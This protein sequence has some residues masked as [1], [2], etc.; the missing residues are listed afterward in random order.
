[1][2]IRLNDVRRGT[3]EY[4]SLDDRML[5]LDFQ[6][7]NPEAFVEIHKRYGGLA[8]HVCR[9]LLAN[10]HDAE[11]ALQETMIR[12]F[13][14]LYRFNG[15]YKLQPWISRIA[16]NVSLDMIRARARRPV[17]DDNAVDEHDHVDP[18]DRPEE[19]FER[20]VQRD[21]VLS[22][23][24]DLPDTHRHALILRELEGRSHR[25]IGAAMGISSSQAKALIH[26]AKGSFRR[27]W[28][29]KVAERGGLAGVAFLPLLWLVRV[30]DTV[31]RV[32]DRAGQT[33]QAAQTAVPEVVT[34]AATQSVVATTSSS[35]FGE[36]VIAAGMT[37]L[38]AG[39]VTVGATA[40]A[41]HDRD[42]DRQGARA[43]ASPAVVQPS[44]QP[45][46]VIEPK[47]ERE[48]VIE[49]STPKEALVPPLVIEAEEVVEPSPTVSP[50]VT[51]ETPSPVPTE[52]PSPEPT[53][54]PSPDPVPT[55]PPPPAWSFDTVG[56]GAGQFE[57]TSSKVTGRAG[58]QVVFSE[59][60]VAPRSDSGGSRTEWVHVEYWGSMIDSSG[61]TGLWL[62]VD[63]PD[64]TY[65]FDGRGF[66]T[67][68]SGAKGEGVTYEF[69]GSYA[70]A[71]QQDSS[72]DPATTDTLPLHGG[73]FVLRLR[74]WLDG[75]SL[76]SVG[77]KLSEA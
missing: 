64:G 39:G 43:T 45:P 12:V 5:V 48:R 72:V 63:A 33:F 26:R 44:P 73:T 24:S 10:Q 65:R 54:E 74:F 42:A 41:K 6:A 17:H 37:L 16:T 9:R 29:Q 56:L 71:E 36:R 50:P 3:G 62:W 58:Q 59:T 35:G 21:L 15:R 8:R 57:R 20:L 69:S 31:R 67:S 19:A 51:S 38:V 53:Q 77:M 11:E 28:M 14:G 4:D 46:K 61:M 1:M 22:V 34:S 2:V 68:V 49:K 32:A 75:T 52:S 23:L 70:L 66:L 76:Y 47:P 60:A 30:A 55:V 27:R 18:A 40:I 13:Q 7:G 25:D